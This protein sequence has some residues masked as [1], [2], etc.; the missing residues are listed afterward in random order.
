MLIVLWLIWFGFDDAQSK[1]APEF[2]ILWDV[3]CCAL[4]GLETELHHPFQRIRCKTKTTR[5]SM[6]F[7]L[8][9]FRMYWL[10]FLFGWLRYFPLFRLGTAITL[11]SSPLHSIKIRSNEESFFLSLLGR[12]NRTFRVTD[13]HV[14]KADR[15]PPQW[16]YWTTAVLAEKSKWIGEDLKGCTE[17]IWRHGVL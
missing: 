16:N 2:G 13:P 6:V 5:N 8:E 14:T 12:G 1:C 9:V 17:T 7:R 4:T 3:R 10:S 11:V 15:S